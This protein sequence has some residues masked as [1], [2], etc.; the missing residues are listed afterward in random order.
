M[1]RNI[2]IVE[3]NNDKY[4]FQSV[5]KH[6]NYNI[7]VE[8]PIFADEDY[9][10]LE[11]LD[12][13]K[14]TKALKDLKAD[15]QK[16]DIDRVGIII[17]IDLHSEADR[18]KFIHDC[19][20]KVFPKAALLDRVNQFI[21]LNFDDY[22]I[23]LACYFTNVDGKGELETVL[24][25]IKSQDSTHAD[26]LQ[27]WREC[28]TRNSKQI[29]DKSF[30]KL[31]IANY[32]RYDTSTKDDKKDAAKKLTLN[33]ALENKSFIWNLNHPALDDLKA[34]FRLFHNPV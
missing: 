32:V 16:E 2:L 24:K 9:R 22:Q 14:L 17:D 29:T 12:S 23:Q 21:E 31:W 26:C 20:V 8:S 1:G 3:S 13:S 11:G 7:K 34:F 28:L 30:D 19:L 25:L 6:L 33:Y 5:I 4:F 27:S 10:P 18:I 15:I